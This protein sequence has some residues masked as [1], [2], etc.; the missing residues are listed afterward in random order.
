MVK[1]GNKMETH[2][3]FGKLSYIEK[4]E[5]EIKYEINTFLSNSPFIWV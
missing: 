4:Y 2:E 3:T 1:L 5:L